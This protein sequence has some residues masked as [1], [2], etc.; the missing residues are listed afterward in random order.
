M[1]VACSSPSWGPSSSSRR[2]SRRSSSPAVREPRAAECE[3]S[4]NAALTR[5]VG[6]TPLWARPSRQFQLDQFQLEPF[7]DEPF[8]LLPFH[9]D[10]FQLLPFQLE[11]FHDEPFQLLPF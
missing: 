4:P 7:H 5:R 1:T 6:P 8:Q 2:F 3:R 9:E 11:P 10:P